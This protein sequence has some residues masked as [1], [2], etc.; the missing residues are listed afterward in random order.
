MSQSTIDQ[1]NP[2]YE[3]IEVDKKLSETA[4]WRLQETYFTQSGLN[5]WDSKVPF[6]STSR[7][8]FCQSYAELVL[9]FLLDW[10]EHLDF[11]EPF[12]IIELGG[13]TGCFTYRFLNALLEGKARFKRLEKLRIR[14]V[15]T[16]FTPTIIESWKKIERLQEHVRNGVLD[17]A[18]YKPEN[19]LSIKLEIEG[20][21]LARGVIKNPIVVIANYFF[22]SI[23]QD[24]FRIVDGKLQETRF[25]LFR[26][27][28]NCN[29][30]DPL[31]AEDILLKEEFK[32]CDDTYY[33][34]S[35]LDEILEQYR[36]SMKEAS[37]IFPV[38]GFNSLDNLARISDGRILLLSADK[39]F[40]S[41]D[42]RQI[43]GLWPQQ[44]TAHG[45]FSFDV[46]YEAMSRYFQLKGGTSHLEAGDHTSLC[47]FFGT[48]LKEE[49]NGVKDY[50]EH[51]IAGRDL[52]NSSYNLEGL[53][54]QALSCGAHNE[55][56]SQLSL[57]ISLV[58]FFSYEPVVFAIVYDSLEEKLIIEL[59][60]IDN[61]KRQKLVT[62]LMR[63]WQ[64]IFLIDKRFDALDYILRFLLAMKCAE[65]CLECCK[66]SLIAF[67]PL[68]T[69]LDNCALSYQMLGRLDRA[70][71]FFRRSYE[72]NPD[73]LWAKEGMARCNQQD[74][75]Q[76]DI[77][78]Q[79][80]VNKRELAE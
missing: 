54:H 20:T 50:F 3:F 27:S 56:K 62:L 18:A 65:E 35:I 17:F 45:A 64:N 1:H 55:S 75:N 67:G 24:A 71:E 15:L 70:Y 63:V 21:T 80:A 8:P 10:T 32:D 68:R 74:S 72:L 33:G 39:G 9:A 7:V 25:A 49:L 30:K 12:Y 43:K 42:S 11:E 69:I 13:G 58:E 34:K 53:V 36:Q 47:F 19:D 78:Q 37:V 2:H 28:R 40:T 51:F 61:E 66:T 57:F 6:Y 38:G 76:Q 52:V 29:L 5:A 23:R 77:N 59:A 4:L 48:T 14:H 60:S 44:F 41:I 79:D 16:D 73:H 22:D 46:N 31:K 26:D